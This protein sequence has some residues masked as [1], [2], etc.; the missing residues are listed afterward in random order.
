M[1]KSE[2]IVIL[3]V[4]ILIELSILNGAVFSIFWHLTSF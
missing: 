2:L 4:F 1:K 3:L